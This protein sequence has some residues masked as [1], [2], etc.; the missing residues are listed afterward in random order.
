MAEPLHEKIYQYLYQKI[1]KHE[2]EE[3][4]KLPTESELSDFFQSS[5]APVR[6][7]LEKLGL[8]GFIVRRPGKGTYVAVHQAWPH[9]NLGGFGQEF[10]EKS[11][12]IYCR[13]LKVEE[14]P[15]PAFLQGEPGLENCLTITGVTRVR[16][17]KSKPLYYLHHYVA[18]LERELIQQ[19]E[20]FASMLALYDKY[21][22]A[23][24]QT[25]EV[26]E[27]VGAQGEAAKQLQVPEGTPVM[28]VSRKTYGQDGRLVEY[29]RF[30][31]LTADW[32]YRTSYKNRE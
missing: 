11:A 3:G 1:Q 9:L 15:L 12:L 26:L 16:Y 13:T 6:Q 2:Y 7:A 21:H 27:A 23:I 31:V 29:V 18:G 30:Y 17:Y 4:E 5:K 32:K 14:E 25:A 28:Q 24:G 8:E 20:N 10:S 19:E 22:R